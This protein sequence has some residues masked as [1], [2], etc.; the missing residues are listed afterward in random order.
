MKTPKEIAIGVLE[1]FKGDESRWTKHA[2]ARDATGEFVGPESPNA[3]C[4]CIAGAA[5]LVTDYNRN[6]EGFQERH[7]FYCQL[8]DGTGYNGAVSTY[9]DSDSTTFTEVIHQLEKVAGQETAP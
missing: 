3:T 7:D 5:L 2:V 6:K 1:V 9:N 4:W 8:L